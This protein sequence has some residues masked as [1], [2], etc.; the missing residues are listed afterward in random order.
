MAAYDISDDVLASGCKSS[1]LKLQRVWKYIP[2]NISFGRILHVFHENA[3]VTL[4]EGKLRFIYPDMDNPQPD[5][6]TIAGYQVCNFSALE[7]VLSTD[8]T[9]LSFRP[10]YH[11][12][13][14]IRQS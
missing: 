6:K 12:V 5:A 10:G 8:V 13:P 7:V 14:S 2:E 1:P 9:V 4:Y 3:V 11:I